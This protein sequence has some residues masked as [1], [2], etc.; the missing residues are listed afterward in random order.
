MTPTIDMEEQPITQEKNDCSISICLFMV[1]NVYD[2]FTRAI[3][4]AAKYLEILCKVES[5]VVSILSRIFFADML[6]S[7]SKIKIFL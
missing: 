6:P 2:S 3:D 7:D 5:E 4:K 1:V